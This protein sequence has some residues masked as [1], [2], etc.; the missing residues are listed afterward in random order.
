MFY[1]ESMVTKKKQAIHGVVRQRTFFYPVEGLS[2]KAV[3]Q[4]EADEKLEV[5]MK[6]QEVGDVQS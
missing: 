4:A 2:I 5:I 1:I 3:T 6:E